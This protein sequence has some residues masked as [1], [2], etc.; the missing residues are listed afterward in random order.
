M[1]RLLLDINPE[2][3]L[4]REI[5][6]I[7]DE[8]QILQHI[9]DHQK[10]VLKEFTLNVARTIVPDVDDGSQALAIDAS[11]EQNTVI[12]GQGIRK[13]PGSEEKKRA[14]WTLACAKDLSN[15]FDDRSAELNNLH[16]SAKHTQEAVS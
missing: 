10:R 9:M 2:G 14:Q 12:I 6:D 1:H 7:I 13:M 5:N 15:S 3:K 11:K 4:V 8:L 16:A